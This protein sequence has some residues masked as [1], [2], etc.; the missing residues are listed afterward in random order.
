M[1]PLAVASPWF[2]FEF[3]NLETSLQTTEFTEENQRLWNCSG[4]PQGG[5]LGRI[6]RGLFSVPSV[7]EAFSDEKE[8][9]EG[10]RQK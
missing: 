4:S 8:N 7:A 5:V 2:K 3:M 10:K 6:G 1:I 9:R